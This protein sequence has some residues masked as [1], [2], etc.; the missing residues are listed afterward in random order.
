MRTRILKF[1]H[2]GSK[3]NVIAFNLIQLVSDANQNE[4]ESENEDENENGNENGNGNGNQKRT[5]GRF[6]CNTRPRERDRP[7]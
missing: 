6:I 4:N 2:S 3:L 7:T 5:G 1:D